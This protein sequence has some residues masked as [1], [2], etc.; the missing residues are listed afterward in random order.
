MMIRLAAAMLLA[1]SVVAQAQAPQTVRVRGQVEQIADRTLTV[2]SREGETLKIKLNDP[3][4]VMAVS[5]LDMAAIKQ[6]SFVGV[7]STKGADG[8]HYA[9]EVLVFPESARGSGEGHYPWDLKPESMMTNATVASVA[10]A[11]KGQE[12]KLKYKQSDQPVEIVVPPE[13]PI[14]TFAPGSP[15][16]LKPGTHVFIGAAAKGADGGLS[17]GRVLAGVDGLVPPM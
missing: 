6:D 3:L 11:P 14:V 12:L 15:D 2:K 8:K 1:S 10:A 9:L 13:T 4:T 16:L 17:T 5:K 7:A